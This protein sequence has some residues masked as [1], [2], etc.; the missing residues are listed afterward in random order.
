MLVAVFGKQL[1][2]STNFSHLDNFFLLVPALSVAHAEHMVIAKDVLVRKGWRKSATS[3]VEPEIGFTDDG[4]TMGNNFISLSPVGD[5]FILLLFRNR[6]SFNT[7]EAME[8]IRFSPLVSIG[9]RKIHTGKKEFR[10]FC[11]GVPKVSAFF[12]GKSQN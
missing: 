3:A 2:D 11:T 8:S 6:L 10:K 5:F 7:S 4:L 12:V 1:R 9:G